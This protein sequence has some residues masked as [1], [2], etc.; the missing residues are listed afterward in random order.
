MGQY[1]NNRLTYN[2]EIIRHILIVIFF[3]LRDIGNY[4]ICHEYGAEIAQSVYLLTTGWT[5]KGSEFE[6]PQGNI[7]L[8]FM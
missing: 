8:L 7:F 1:E 2:E 6:S 3:P 4:I 5:T